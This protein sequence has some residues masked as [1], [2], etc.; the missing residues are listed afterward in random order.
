MQQK[1]AAQSSSE[2]TRQDF[3]A[4]GDDLPLSAIDEF[5]DFASQEGGGGGDPPVITLADDVDA[6]L[7]LSPQVHSSA[8][9][10]GENHRSRK[11]Q[12]LASPLRAPRG[13]NT[14][15]SSS[16]VP[17]QSSTISSTLPKSSSDSSVQRSK[18]TQDTTSLVGDMSARS[19]DLSLKRRRSQSVQ[20][21]FDDFFGHSAPEAP[22][23]GKEGSPL[24]RSSEELFADELPTGDEGAAT[25]A[26]SGRSDEEH[27]RTGE[28]SQSDLIDEC[29][30][31]IVTPPLPP[32]EPSPRRLRSRRKVGVKTPPCV[33]DARTLLDI[34][35]SPSLCEKEHSEYQSAG[36][37]LS[38]AASSALN[39]GS[40]GTPLQKALSLVNGQA[41]DLKRYLSDETA[42][43]CSA[44]ECSIVG[45]WAHTCTVGHLWGPGKVSC[46][47]RCPHFRGIFIAYS[48]CP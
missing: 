24:C 6:T 19:K 14:E 17:V 10:E 36:Q 37:M 47:K 4:Y 8:D 44:A 46:I 7:L 22:A 18:G 21:S 43:C 5:V 1:S 30:F 45:E 27:D 32:P 12:K 34:S 23:S 20:L 25:P 40:G 13:K 16:R 9:E 15:P 31:G 11:K 28:T 39:A 41:E 26:A 29:L 2:A 3:D 35:N 33:T 42:P 38:P 48:K